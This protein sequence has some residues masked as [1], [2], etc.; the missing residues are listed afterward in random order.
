MKKGTPNNTKNKELGTLRHVD[1]YLNF[2]VWVAQPKELRKPK[3]Q[4]ELSKKFGVGED[5]LS[6][7]KNRDG[8]W[9]KVSTQRQK[10][11]KEK[12]SDVINALYK[13]IL[14]NGSASEVRLWM[15]MIEGWSV[16][17]VIVED[18]YADIRDMTD[19]E[20]D[21]E[22]KKLEDFFNKK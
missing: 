15:E 11:C 10:W 5:T 13:R 17:E 8:F 18:R 4:R 2:I 12:T 9:E 22:I 1:E 3:T 6:E 19:A 21:M 16:K 14:E 7:W 20:L